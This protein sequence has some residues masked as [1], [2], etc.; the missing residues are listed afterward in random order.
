MKAWGKHPEVYMAVRTGAGNTSWMRLRQRNQAGPCLQEKKRES[1]AWHG[2]GWCTWG[3]T[4]PDTTTCWAIQLEGSSAEEN[5][6]M[7]VDNKSN[8]TSPMLLLLR[9]PMGCMTQSRSKEVILSSALHWW[10]TW[11]S[12]LT[13]S[14]RGNKQKPEHRRIL[15][16]SRDPFQPKPFCHS[17]LFYL[18]RCP[19]LKSI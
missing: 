12:E 1:K 2:R 5:L 4:A 15:M 7:L 16:T 3:G 14:K 6:G 8:M 10:G 11:S 18:T 9:R 19:V 13:A 17:R